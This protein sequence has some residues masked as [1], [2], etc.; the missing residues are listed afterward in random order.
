MGPFVSID[1]KRACPLVKV[2]V[3][4]RN[5]CLMPAS[6]SRVTPSLISIPRRAAREIPDMMAIGTASIKGHGVAAT[7]TASAR[8]ASPLMYQA[9][10]AISNVKGMKNNA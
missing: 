2:P 9:V 4:S 10:A 8:K 3:L 5:I 6:A 7:K 1:C